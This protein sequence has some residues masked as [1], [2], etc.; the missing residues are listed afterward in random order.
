M[1]YS[2]RSV[3]SSMGRSNQTYHKVK[4]DVNLELRLGSCL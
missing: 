3:R 4:V 2:E 1:I